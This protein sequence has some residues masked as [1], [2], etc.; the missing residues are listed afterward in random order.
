MEDNETS[1]IIDVE[2]YG[3]EKDQAYSYE[4][5]VMMAI[6]KCIEAGGKEMRS[7]YYNNKFDRTGNAHRVWIP[8]TR[9]IYI[10]CVETS[11]DIL[12]NKIDHDDNAKKN[13]IILKKELKDIYDKLCDNEKLDWDSIPQS[14]RNKRSEEGIIQINKSLSKGLPYYEEHI[15]EKLRTK[16]L[17]FRELMR[18][19]SDFE[20]A[21]IEEY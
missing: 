15:N 18:V 21:D 7:G 11:E 4:V 16:R 2:N 13:L 5:L 9:M 1:D 6:K 19:A 12:I 20:V 8:D 14:V 3:S 17:I 10:E